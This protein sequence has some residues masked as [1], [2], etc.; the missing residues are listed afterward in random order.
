MLPPEGAGVG[1]DGA[2]ISRPA[3]PEADLVDTD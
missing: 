2:G 3:S 1:A